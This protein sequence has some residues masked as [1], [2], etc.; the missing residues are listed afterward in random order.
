M[1]F[2]SKME[3]EKAIIPSVCSQ[4]KLVNEMQ[5]KAFNKIFKL[6]LLVKKIKQYICTLFRGYLKK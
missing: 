3:R 2:S 1:K 5:K 6:F 4:L